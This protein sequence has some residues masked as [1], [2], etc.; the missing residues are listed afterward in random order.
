MGDFDSRSLTYP[1]RHDVPAVDDLQ[2]E[3]M[4]LVGVS[5]SRSRR[6]LFEQ[7]RAMAYAR[8]GRPLPAV[9]PSPPRATVPYLD[10][11]WYC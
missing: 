9:P 3:V 4:R 6:G 1:W 10:E 11:P 5:A 2:D 8:L 7:V